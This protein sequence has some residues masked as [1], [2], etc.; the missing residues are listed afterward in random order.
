M[1]SS[2]PQQQ[3]PLN[4]PVEVATA[5][6]D[7]IVT[8]SNR[9]VVEFLDAWPNWPSSIAVL[10]GP[11][12]AGKSHLA[13]VWASNSDAFIVPADRLEGEEAGFLGNVVVEDLSASNLNETVL[14][15]LIN[16]TKSAG[17]HL[18][19][20]S[21]DWPGDWQVELPDLLSRMKTATLLELN[22]PDDPLL[23][24]VLVKLFSDRQLLVE[25]PVL[26]YLSLR[27][28]RSLAAAHALVEHLDRISLVQKRAVTKPLAAQALRDMGLQD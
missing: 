24:G 17:K 4:L 6:E 23:L 3:L 5:R 28:E 15:H 21:R 8:K 19:I 12:G 22:E 1:S 11:V 7:L 9:Q 16:T 2:V 26:E 10:A 14:F 27:M 20:T 25:P 13:G 18:L